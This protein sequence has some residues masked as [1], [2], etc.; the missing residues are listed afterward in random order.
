MSRREK[1]L[2]LTILDNALLRLFVR[3]AL[4]VDSMTDTLTNM[5]QLWG[6]FVNQTT[7]DQSGAKK[8]IGEC[9]ERL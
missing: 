2:S 4:G 6:E 5:G 1:P 9:L 3:L 7:D 8:W